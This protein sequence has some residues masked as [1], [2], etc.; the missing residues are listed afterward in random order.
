ML[1]YLLTIV[2]SIQT[3]KTC[4]MGTKENI[5]NVLNAISEKGLTF[6]AYSNVEQR[7]THIGICSKRSVWDWFVAHNY[8]R[9]GIVSMDVEHTYSQNTGRVKKS[10]MH[11]INLRHKYESLL[12]VKLSF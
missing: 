3:N 1:V 10:I 6:E 4:K 5:D 2:L 11:R 12:N 9:D 7:D 8:Y